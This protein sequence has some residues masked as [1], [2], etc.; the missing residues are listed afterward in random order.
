M[1]KVSEIYNTNNDESKSSLCMPYTSTPKL[2][3]I[4]YGIAL[5]AL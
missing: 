4:N 5:L 3:N 2:R 1:E